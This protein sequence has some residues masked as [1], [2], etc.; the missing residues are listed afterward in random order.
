MH[1]NLRSRMALAAG[2]LLL[3]SPLALPA[4]AATN[5]DTGTAGSTSDDFCDVGLDADTIYDGRPQGDDNTCDNDQED[6]S[7]VSTFN[8]GVLTG[9]AN[10]GG[11]PS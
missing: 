6:T 5:S 4:Q 1:H 11:R 10:A 9:C 3:L 2:L 8:G 7:T